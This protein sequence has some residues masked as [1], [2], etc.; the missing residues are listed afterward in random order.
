MGV[1]PIREACHE[2]DAIRPSGSRS[3]DEAHPSRVMGAARGP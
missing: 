2:A 3:P 1:Q